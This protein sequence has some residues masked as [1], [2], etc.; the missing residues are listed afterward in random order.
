[1]KNPCIIGVFKPLVVGSTPTTG[2]KQE[3]PCIARVFPFSPYFIGVFG[4]YNTFK[5]KIIFSKKL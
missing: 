4:T 1:L 3:N 2:T 5:M